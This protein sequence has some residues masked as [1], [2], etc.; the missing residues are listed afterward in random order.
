MTS[1][2]KN[3]AFK[4]GLPQEFEIVDIAELYHE[5]KE[6]LTE[7]HRANF[8]HIIWFQNGSPTH[9]VD[10]NPIQIKSNTL[11]FLNKDI[12]QRFDNKIKF[13]GKAILFTD[14]FFCKTLNDATFLR[15]TVLFNDLF[16]VSQIQ[17][18]N[19]SKIFEDL[20]QLMT[21]ELQ[22]PKDNSQADILKNL[23]HNFLLQADRERRKQDFTEIKKSIERDYVL[24]FKDFLEK[25]YKNQ[26]QVNYYAKLIIISEKRLNLATSK[27]LGK[28]PKEIIDYRVM[29]EAKRLLAHTN[30]SVKEIAFDLGFEEPTNFIKFFKKHSLITPI[31]FR[32]KNRLA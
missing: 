3:Y 15:G 28:S 6:T 19:Q 10:F 17:L 9:L 20:L 8:Y 29:L 12:V 16:S 21:N 13:S 27:I 11:L 32:E 26:K 30:E 4:N 25:N 1:E 14:D 2:I 24:L 5:F 22:N 18:N 7:T 23:L 31:E